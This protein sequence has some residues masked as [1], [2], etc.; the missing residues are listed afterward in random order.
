MLVPGA[1]MQFS[2]WVYIF[3]FKFRAHACTSLF[4]AVCALRPGYIAAARSHES[5]PNINPD[6]T[7]NFLGCWCARC[8]CARGAAAAEPDL[9]DESFCSSAAATQLGSRA[10]GRALITG[11]P[12]ASRSFV[13]RS[14]LA[15]TF[16]YQKRLLYQQRYILGARA[17]LTDCE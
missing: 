8:E 1:E 9:R 6:T 5:R 10:A 17:L 7:C 11:S 13:E 12:L 4:A 16:I 14:R 3:P 15:A 2:T